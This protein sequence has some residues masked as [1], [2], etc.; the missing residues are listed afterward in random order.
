[1]INR[2]ES[3]ESDA[4][5]KGETIPQSADVPNKDDMVANQADVDLRKRMSITKAAKRFERYGNVEDA[6]NLVGLVHDIEGSVVGKKTH[7]VSPRLRKKAEAR[8]RAESEAG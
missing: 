3:T 1:M 2:D 4:D 8:A 5:A 7:V 6:Q